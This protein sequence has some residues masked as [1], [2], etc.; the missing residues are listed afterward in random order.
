MGGIA[1]GILY[2]S[3]H[4]IGDEPED[5]AVIKLAALARI[6][7]ILNL[8]DTNRVIKRKAILAP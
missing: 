6:A 4:P 7:T 2:R 3:S 8:T 5:I 1:P